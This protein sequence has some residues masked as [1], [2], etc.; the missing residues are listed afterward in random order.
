VNFDNRPIRRWFLSFQET[1][2]GGAWKAD[3]SEAEGVFPGVGG[4]HSPATVLE[5]LDHVVVAVRD[6]ASAARDSARLL[7]RGSSWSG[8]HPA[9]GTANE[10]FRLD[11]V[12]LELL[13]P[14]GAG[15]LAEAL[16]AHLGAK[17]EGLFALA[18]G[19]R[20]AEACRAAF[21]AR[22]LEPAPVTRGLGRDLPSGAFREWRSVMLPPARTRGLHLFAIQHLSPPELLPKVPPY[23]D[24][25]AAVTGLDHV[26]VR[27]AAAEASRAL[28]GEGLGLRLALD[29]SF[30]AFDFRALFF[31]VGGVT[32]EVTAPLSAPPRPEQEDALWGLAW[33][34]PDVA[35]AQ[36]RLLAAGFDV[37]PV[38]AGRKPGTAV[39]TVR[40]DPCGVATLLV[41]PA[42]A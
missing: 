16:R 8:E 34:V 36:R 39:C 41:G 17:G 29:R 33:S 27:S 35:A 28:F 1:A 2:P 9:W 7:G 32:V 11:D 18:F 19:T 3:S 12:Y 23:A 40:G 30:E 26:V 24:P 38:R 10:L 22:G 13:A 15:P 20:D 6:L 14:V 31:R 25:A 21:A 37:S 42:P 5:T 4:W